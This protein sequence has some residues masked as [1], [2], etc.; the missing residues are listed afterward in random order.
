VSGVALARG[1]LGRAGLTAERFLADPYGAPGARM[2][3]TGDLGRR[4]GDGSVEF[5]GRNDH[6]VKIR[7]FRIELGE[8]ET[9]LCGFDGV[10][11][12]V[13]LAREDAPGEKQLAAYYQSDRPLAAEALR[14]ALAASLPGYMV[15][16]AFVRMPAW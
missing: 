7:G 14:D 5:L 16:A 11:E 9:R 12:A 1:Y 15:P 3:R 8:I 10:R 2:Y 6:Q 13:V 4:R